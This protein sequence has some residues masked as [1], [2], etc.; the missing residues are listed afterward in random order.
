MNFLRLWVTGITDPA[1]AFDELKGKPAPAWGLA[2]VMIRF[3]FTSLTTILS[4]HLLDCEPFVPSYLTFLRTETY[5][6]AEIFFLPAFGFA[7]WLLGSALVYLILRLLGRGSDFDQILNV[8]G[9]GMLIPMPAVWLWDWTTIAL[10]WY[11]TTVMAASHAV[12]ALWG[13]MLYTIGFKEVLGFRTAL[14]RGL[15][16]AI[17]GLY[18]GLAMVFIR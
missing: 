12:F 11:K 2:A 17:T 15:A 9:M 13:A 4:L 5:Y 3:L 16:A 7:L 14:A 8:V 6:R 10:D 18:V 1:Q